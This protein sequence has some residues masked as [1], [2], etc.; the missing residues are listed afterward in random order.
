LRQAF[1][2]QPYPIQVN[3]PLNFKTAVDIDRLAE[4]WQTLRKVHYKGK[5][6]KPRKPSANPFDVL[7]ALRAD[8]SLQT[9]SLKFGP[10]VL[11]GLAIQQYGLRD[12]KL[13]VPLCAVKCG[14]GDLIL[15]TAFYDLN[16]PQ[17]SHSQKFQ[18]TEADLKSLLGLGAED[19]QV[20]G[21]VTIKGELQGIG[22][23]PGAS[24]EGTAKVHLLGATGIEPPAAFKLDDK[25]PTNAP[26][27]LHLPPLVRAASKKVNERQDLPASELREGMPETSEA[28]AP[29]NSL[30][31][32]LSTTLA[33]FAMPAQ[34]LAFEP[35][36]LETIISH[37]IVELRPV[38]FIGRGPAEGLELWA[39]GRVNLSD[40]SITDPLV[41][42][43]KQLPPAA[44]KRLRLSDWSLAEQEAF[45]GDLR[46]ASQLALR[47]TGTWKKA[48][49][50]IPLGDIRRRVRHAM[51]PPP[52]PPAPPPK[53]GQE[54]VKPKPPPEED[55]SLS[56]GE[57]LF[58]IYDRLSKQPKPSTEPTQPPAKRR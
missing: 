52:P 13:N 36:Q 14:G 31:T 51:P 44:L 17:V 8:G 32:A 29:W 20:S 58:L 33:G 30:F 23:T 43:P 55:P 6:P 27:V 46:N 2:K 38:R 47:L 42:Y 57:S 50:S 45:M 26:F 18:L 34:S 19:Y 40:G 15:S 37:G 21:N 5:L 9:P 39:A 54:P 1:A 56:A 16:H 22:P 48:V 4:A 3:L 28:A 10:W 53:R 35:A 41:I 12:L 24:W 11:D 7:R 25:V 49:V